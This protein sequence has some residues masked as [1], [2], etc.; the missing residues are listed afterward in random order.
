MSSMWPAS[1]NDSWFRVGRLEVTTVMFVV[2]V[3]VASWLAWVI[4]P[5]LSSDF[6]L[7]PGA[8]LLYTS[9]CV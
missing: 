9:R 7:I 1:S 4:Y 8:C 3:T 6:A 2:L 5:P